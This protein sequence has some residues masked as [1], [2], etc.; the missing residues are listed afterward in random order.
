MEIPELFPF[1][2]APFTLLF[3]YK[4]EFA[5]DMNFKI[6]GYHNF[7]RHESVIFYIRF[8]LFAKLLFQRPNVSFM[9]EISLR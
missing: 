1:C 7:M 6:H 9:P 3:P 8:I 5:E 2:V 4:T